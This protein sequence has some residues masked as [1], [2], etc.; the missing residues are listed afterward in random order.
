MAQHPNVPRCHGLRPGM[1]CPVPDDCDCKRMDAEMDAAYRMTNRNDRAFLY[2]I[3]ALAL[4]VISS[5]VVVWA[6]LGADNLP[7]CLTKQAARAKYPGK[8]LY[9]HTEHHCWD[10]SPGRGRHYPTPVPAPKKPS[11]EPDGSIV[12]KQSPGQTVAYPT[13][14]AGGGTV[15]TMLQPDAMIVAGI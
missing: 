10:A 12:P 7:S 4:A 5:F 15:S 6:A 13:L 9:W 2:V 14:M 11:I 3:T 1:P 8:Y